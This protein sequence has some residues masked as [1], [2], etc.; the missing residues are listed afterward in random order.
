MHTSKPLVRDAQEKKKSTISKKPSKSAPP[1]TS[2]KSSEYIQESDEEEPENSENEKQSDSDDESLPSNPTEVLITANGKFPRPAGSS[3]SSENESESDKSGSEAD[4]KEE[5]EEEPVIATKQT[6]ADPFE[7]STEPSRS[8][9]VTFQKPPPYKPPVGFEKASLDSTPK[10]GHIFNNLSLEGKQIWY[11]TAPASLP[12]SS[13]RQMSLRDAIDSKPIVNHKG[14][15]Y[16]FVRDSAEDKTYTKIMVPNGSDDG[17]RMAKSSVDQILHL[18]QVVQLPGVHVSNSVATSSSKATVP[19]MRPVR[20]QPPGLKMRF[21]PIGFGDGETGKIGSSSSSLD[22]SIGS[23]SDEELEQ[24]AATFRQ[25]ITFAADSSEAEESPEDSESD[26]KSSRADIEM[27]EAPPL[28]IK[29][30]VKGR[31]NNTSKVPSSHEVTNGSLK[32]KHSGKEDRKPKHSLSRS[33]ST[34]DRELR[35]LKKNQTAPQRSLEHKASALI[36]P[37]NG[38]L[39]RSPAKP[40]ITSSQNSITRPPTSARLPQSSSPPRLKVSP[41]KD[42]R[43]SPKKSNR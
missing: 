5:E 21:R 17:Y 24:P 14:H 19:A 20:Q 9:I 26:E 7:K 40:E 32:R 29:S 30:I 16:G 42:D 34:D 15:D 13:I 27:T 33:S 11:F 31:T 25:P 35:R 39:K 37:R 10:T 1:P 8:S 28:L 4:D 43:R 41:G 22:G 2:F 12:V 3:S 18:Q 36:E 38:S 6:I 23:A